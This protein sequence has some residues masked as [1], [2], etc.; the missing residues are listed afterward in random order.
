MLNKEVKSPLINGNDGVKKLLKALEVH[1]DDLL[2]Q[3]ESMVKLYGTGGIEDAVDLDQV[4][5]DLPVFIETKR[6][7]VWYT[8]KAFEYTY[9]NTT[10]RARPWTKELINLKN[11]VERKTNETYNSCLLNLYHNGD[12]GMA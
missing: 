6:K 7:I 5:G 3:Y 12:E 1:G 2:E 10:K 4:G 9:S 8:S 11:I